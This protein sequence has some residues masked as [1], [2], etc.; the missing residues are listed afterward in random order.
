MS[1]AMGAGRDTAGDA[2]RAWNLAC[3]QRGGTSESRY[4]TPRLS[5]G[6]PG[7]SKPC[8][9]E[10]QPAFV[11]AASGVTTLLQFRSWEPSRPGNGR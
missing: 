3:E 11:L 5:A 10:V 9:S 1:Q 4:R 7:L 8:P 6:P 2:Q